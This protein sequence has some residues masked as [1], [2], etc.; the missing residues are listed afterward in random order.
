MAMP[1]NLNRVL[2]PYPTRFADRISEDT[3]ALSA[4]PVFAQVK[5]TIQRRLP[6]IKADVERVVRAVDQL[7]ILV[8][9]AI[10]GVAR[11]GAELLHV[12]VVRSEDPTRLREH[13]RKI[14]LFGG[15]RRFLDCPERIVVGDAP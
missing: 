5:G 10:T 12:A 9:V 3:F 4:Y 2:R 1:I 15:Q 6:V 11:P 8:I 7:L 14:A 13:L